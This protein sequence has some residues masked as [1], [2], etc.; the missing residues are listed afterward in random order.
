M[1]AGTHAGEILGNRVV[2]MRLGCVI[3]AMQGRPQFYEFSSCRYVGVINRSQKDINNG[4]TVAAHLLWEKQYVDKHPVYST[5]SNVSTSTLAVN[6]NRELVKH[7]G[8]CLDSL[9]HVGLCYAPHPRR[10]LH[11]EH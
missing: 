8:R 4:K 7:I 2:P 5:M 10:A 11:D 1:D 3:T 6:L 9:I